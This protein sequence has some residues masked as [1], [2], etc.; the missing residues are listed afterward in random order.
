[1]LLKRA[2]GLAGYL[3]NAYPHW[4]QRPSHWRPN[5]GESALCV[6]NRCVQAQQQRQPG[7]PRLLVPGLFAISS[8]RAMLQ[9]ALAGWLECHLLHHPIY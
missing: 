4:C 6:R 2:G 7:F 9:H 8:V 3:F 1:M 5:G